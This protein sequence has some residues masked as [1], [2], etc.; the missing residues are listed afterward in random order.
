MSTTDAAIMQDLEALLLVAD[1]L[2]EIVDTAAQAGPAASLT[3]LA[4]RV[5]VKMELNPLD[6]R[7][8]LNAIWNIK[9]YQRARGVEGDELIDQ[10]NKLSGKD[11][12]GRWD[13]IKEPVLNV[14]DDVREDHP[15]FVSIKAHLL[16]YEHQNLVL[17]TRLVTDIRPVFDTL[18][19]NIFECV[20]IHTLNV[21]H[22]DGLRDSL[23]SFAMDSQ[24][25]DDLR[26]A[27]ERAK[28]KMEVVQ[29][30]MADFNPVILPE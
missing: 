20:V 27:C 11:S 28:R 26:N 22:T 15:I 1:R 7:D 14:L 9:R 10:L 16:A 30:K 29:E 17:S 24:D 19:E 8:A 25:V 21:K 18:G 5:A 6:I 23:T 4:K 13:D 2:S 12:E 3:G